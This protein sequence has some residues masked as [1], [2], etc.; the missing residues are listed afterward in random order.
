M[1]SAI[2][3]RV[4]ACISQIHLNLLQRWNQYQHAALSPVHPQ[5]PVSIYYTVFLKPPVIVE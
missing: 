4:H 3:A 2:Y 1:L 5:Q